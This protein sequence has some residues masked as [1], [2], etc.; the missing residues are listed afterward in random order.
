MTAPT[1]NHR[2]VGPAGERIYYELTANGL[3]QLAL[4][5]ADVAD[6]Q[7]LLDN[8]DPTCLEATR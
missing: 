8:L 4:F 1:R 3:H 2:P 5:A 7:D 6:A